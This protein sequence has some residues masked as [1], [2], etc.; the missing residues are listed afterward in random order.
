M[1]SSL[2][3]IVAICTMNRRKYLKKIM[4]AQQTL[5]SSFEEQDGD[6]YENEYEY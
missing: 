2:L 1:L 5:N 6:Y 3:M 4:L